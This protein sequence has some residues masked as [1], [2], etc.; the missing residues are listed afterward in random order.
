MHPGRVLA[1]SVQNKKTEWLPLHT[2]AVLLLPLHTPWFK[3]QFEIFKL[4]LGILNVVA[5]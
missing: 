5:A 1:S 2:D 4:L 3:R